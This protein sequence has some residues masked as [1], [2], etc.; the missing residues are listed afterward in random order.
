MRLSQKIS[1]L[2]TLEKIVATGGVLIV[3]AAIVGAG[4][5]ATFTSTGQATVSAD[6]GQLKVAMSQ[7]FTIENMAPGDTVYKL[8]P[9]VLPTTGS[10]G[11]LVSALGVFLDTTVD[12]VGTAPDVTGEGKSLKV[13]TEGLTYIIQTCDEVWTPAVTPGPTVAPF[14]CGGTLT[15][16]STNVASHKLSSL[17]GV[18]NTVEFVPS[19][20][21][22]SANAGTGT[23]ITDVADVPLYSMIVIELPTAANNDYQKA[24]WSFDLTVTALQRDATKS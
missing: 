10:A 21:G 24:A 2:G 4:A 9:I 6:A 22:V 15:E 17:E 5:F 16:T 19:D 7:T 3:A 14:T 20:F 12:T 18:V 11:N 1:Q 8:L 13:G 23:F